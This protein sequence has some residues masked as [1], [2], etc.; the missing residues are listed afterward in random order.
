MYWC[1]SVLS[2]DRG[3]WTSRISWTV[4]AANT[5]HWRPQ[6]HFPETLRAEETLACMRNKSGEDIANKSDQC[7]K[8]CQ[9]MQNAQHGKHVNQSVMTL[10]DSRLAVC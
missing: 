7:P 1:Q 4:S 2:A 6:K 3:R 5:K 10:P 9:K 8:H